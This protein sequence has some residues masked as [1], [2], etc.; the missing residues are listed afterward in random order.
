MTLLWTQDQSNMLPQIRRGLLKF[1]LG[2]QRVTILIPDVLSR[3]YMGRFLDH[4][5][6]TLSLRRLH[7]DRCHALLALQG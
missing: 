4:A 5:V 6:A 3:P 1:I 7:S 2:G